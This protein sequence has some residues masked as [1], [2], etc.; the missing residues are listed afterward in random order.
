M[1][2]RSTQSPASCQWHGAMLQL[3]AVTFCMHCMHC[4]TSPTPLGMC[5]EANM[6]PTPSVQLPHRHLSDPH[7]PS[8]HLPTCMRLSPLL[9]PKQEY[10]VSGVALLPTQGGT[11]EKANMCAPL[12]VSLILLLISFGLWFP[13]RSLSPIR[14][15]VSTKLSTVLKQNSGSSRCPLN[16]NRYASAKRGDQ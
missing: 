14:L 13:L 4:K 2:I 8:P 11:P 9:D 7:P 3:A 10:L 16:W 1:R 12:P 6:F 5:P 15:K